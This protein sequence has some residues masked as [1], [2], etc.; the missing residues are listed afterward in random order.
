LFDTH[1]FLHGLP[2]ISIQS[3]TDISLHDYSGEKS[4]SVHSSY[5]EKKTKIYV[6]ELK[7]ID[8]YLK[9]LF[10]YIKDQY[11]DDE[12]VVSICSDHG[13]GYIGNSSDM[14][15]EHRIKAPLFLNQVKLKRSKAGLMLVVST[16]SH[17]YWNYLI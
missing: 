6:E 1:H 8:F 12:V 16:T 11:K 17:H 14:L 7:R 15:A 2:D 10:D 3:S 13:Q 4:K 5:S 9:I